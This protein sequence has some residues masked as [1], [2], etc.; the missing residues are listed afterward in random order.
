MVRGRG[1]LP[2]QD[3]TRE[4]D[5]PSLPACN[6]QIVS[7]VEFAPIIVDRFGDDEGLR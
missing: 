7:A 2:G 1:Q 4:H 6:D 5:I 3:K